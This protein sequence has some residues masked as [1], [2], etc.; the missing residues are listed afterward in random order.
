MDADKSLLHLPYAAR[1][2]FLWKRIVRGLWSTKLFLGYFIYEE[3][4]LAFMD[5]DGSRAKLMTATFNSSILRLHLHERN[6][7]LF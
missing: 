5:F 1:N 2:L 4:P 6:L 7:A 3:H